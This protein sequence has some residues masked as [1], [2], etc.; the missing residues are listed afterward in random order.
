[1]TQSKKGKHEKCKQ[2]SSTH[3]CQDSADSPVVQ[4]DH[5][6]QAFEL[7][8]AQRAAGE[9]SG[10]GKNAGAKTSCGRGCLCSCSELLVLFLLG[11]A[12]VSTS[13][14]SR[15]AARCALLCSSSAA[16]GT[17]STSTARSSLG[18]VESIQSCLF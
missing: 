11:M 18:L 15:P 10:L 5:P 17:A 16:L 8:G 7:V 6:V 12:V 13:S 2:D 4:R 3:I 1:M 14:A 9:D